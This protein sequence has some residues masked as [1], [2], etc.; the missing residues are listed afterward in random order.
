MSKASQEVAER[1]NDRMA[2][3]S[4]RLKHSGLEIDFPE[5]PNGRLG[6]LLGILASLLAGERTKE[7]EHA[8]S[9]DGAIE[10]GKKE[11]LEAS[12]AKDPSKCQP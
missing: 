2:Q 4:K 3:G 9:E 10:C 11:Q 5:I 7:L 1:T 6:P 8:Y 12:I